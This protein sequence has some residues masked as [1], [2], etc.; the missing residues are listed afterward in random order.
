M[1]LF[2]SVILLFHKTN[3]TN[4]Q[5][6]ILSFYQVKYISINYYSILL[7]DKSKENL[8]K[9][10]KGEVGGADEDE[11]V[12]DGGGCDDG[13]ADFVVPEEFAGIFFE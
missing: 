11:A 6:Q 7:H 8:L 13:F 4:H 3:F 12:D 10:V 5:V 2:F 9:T 1:A